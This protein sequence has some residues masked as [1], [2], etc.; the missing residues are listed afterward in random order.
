M[1]GV[2]MRVD[3]NP[4][5]AA[6]ASNNH[7][8]IVAAARDILKQGEHADVLLGRLGQMA[9]RSDT[10]GHPTITLAA[11][12]MLSRLLH[13]IPQPLEGDILPHERGVHGSL[14]EFGAAILFGE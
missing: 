11:A 8:E 6:L 5:V 10:D 12:A 13:T 2:E 4:L 9:A 14:H 1:A 3:L 7:E